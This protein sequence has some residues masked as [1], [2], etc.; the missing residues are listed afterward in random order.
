MPPTPTSSVSASDALTLPA[1]LPADAEN[2][3]SDA[4]TLPATA[5]G[6]SDDA[7]LSATAKVKSS[8]LLSF[9]RRMLATRKK[10]PK[11]RT[12]SRHSNGKNTKLTTFN[13]SEARIQIGNSQ[14]N[15]QQIGFSISP[16][17]PWPRQQTKKDIESR[18][19]NAESGN[20]RND[21]QLQ[22]KDREI[23]RIKNSV[24]DGALNTSGRLSG[25]TFFRRIIDC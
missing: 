6:I 8:Q 10:K 4:A 17:P 16:A 1:T 23:K 15:A 19:R 20:K 24:M 12:I 21:R 2:S 9:S 13:F 3:A 11:S 14:A 5:K 25:C 22:E 18:T 7:N